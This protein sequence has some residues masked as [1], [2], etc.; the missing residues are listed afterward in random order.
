M[1]APAPRPAPTAVRWTDEEDQTILAFIARNAGAQHDW[2]TVAARLTEM[3]AAKGKPARTVDAVRT[4]WERVNKKSRAAA[5]GGSDFLVEQTGNGMLVL[6]DGAGDGH[7]HIPA[8][9]ATRP[10]TERAKWT[11][12]E[13]EI[14]LRGVEELGKKWR[15]IA[16]RLPLCASTGKARTDSS[17]RN[18]WERLMKSAS[19]AG[20]A[21]ATTPPT[22]PAPAPARTSAPELSDAQILAALPKLPA[23][24][25]QEAPGMH[26]CM[27][28][29]AAC[30]HAAGA[31]GGRGMD[32]AALNACIGGL[33]SLPGA[34][35][36]GSVGDGVLCEL[37]ASGMT[38]GQARAA[39]YTCAEARSAG[40]SCPEARAAGF[41]RTEAEAAGYDAAEVEA[42]GYPA[43]GLGVT[44]TDRGRSLSIPEDHPAL[45]AALAMDPAM[46]ASGLAS[47]MD[48]SID[49]MLQNDAGLVA[50]YRQAAGMRL[51]QSQVVGNAR[52]D[53]AGR[54]GRSERSVNR[55]ATRGT[56]N[57]IAA[58]GINVDD[59]LSAAMSGSAIDITPHSS[60]AQRG[61]S[62]DCNMGLAQRANMSATIPD[63]LAAA[64][65]PISAAATR[66]MPPPPPDA[67]AAT[68]S[69]EDFVM[70]ALADDGRSRPATAGLRA[71][72]Q[73]DELNLEDLVSMA[74]EALGDDEYDAQRS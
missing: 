11:Q 50:F 49:R 60:F 30:M 21:S 25:A 41:S 73:L 16:E 45:A 8:V 17:V 15:Q 58:S 32:A 39:E 28:A 35:R 55:S 42:A 14:I 22:A 37:K 51:M 52:Y 31:L 57:S 3:A 56:L 65:T 34:P 54:D 69:D 23:A 40:Y 68:A 62:T 10:P 71:S 2:E 63:I 64:A 27:G 24:G 38:C 61:D 4:R 29:S 48:S 5:A 43:E 6:P 46:D 20:V 33:A 7:L 13:D 59:F 18:R 9:A 66:S 44:D 72:G 1:A 36:P 70:G 26:A 74:T 47:S 19:S 12:E 53:E 67:L